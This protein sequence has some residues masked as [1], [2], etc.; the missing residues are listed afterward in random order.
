MQCCFRDV[1]CKQRGWEGCE[2]HCDLLISR[3]ADL[4]CTL[5]PLL[6]MEGSVGSLAEWMG[7]RWAWIRRIIG[8]GGTGVECGVWRKVP[9]LR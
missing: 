8:R 2:R 5:G 7:V 6:S 4:C 9:Q 1:W 3:I